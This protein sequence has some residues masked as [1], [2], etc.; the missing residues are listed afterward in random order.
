MNGQKKVELV[1]NIMYNLLLAVVLSAIAEMINAGGVQWPGLVID[2]IISFI[3]EMIIVLFLPFT[4]WGLSA[5]MKNAQPGTPKFRWIMSIVTAIPFAIVM[6]GCMSFI[7][8]KMGGAPLIAWL[9]AFCKVC[10]VF[11]VLAS[12][13]AYFLIPVFMGL[14]AKICGV[15]PEHH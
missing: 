3:L 13:C 1:M 12:V 10:P 2:T 15:E 6:S 8:I 5:A 4:K 11:I 7:G 14:A 9:P